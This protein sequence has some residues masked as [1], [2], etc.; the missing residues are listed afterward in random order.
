[1]PQS[2]HAVFVTFAFRLILFGVVLLLQWLVYRRF[3]RWATTYHPSSRWLLITGSS[4]FLL[5]NAAFLAILVYRPHA[6]RFP[7]WFQVAGVYPFMIWYTSTF[8]LGLVFLLV[9]LVKLPFRGALVLGT[10]LGSLREKW[11]RLTTSQ[12]FK[13]FDAQRRQ[14]LRRG[15]EGTAAVAFGSSAYGV[16]VG[17]FA[18]ETDS[19]EL[20]LDRLHPAFDGLTVT[21][22]SDIHSSVFMTK[23]EMDEYVRVVNELKSDLIVVGGDFVNGLTEEV[24]PFAESFSNLKASLGIFG[25]TGNHDY[26]ASDPER[27]IREVEAC[28]IKLLHDEKYILR[29]GDAS[30]TFLGVD[31]IGSARRASERIAVARKGGTEGAT[32]LLCHRPYFLPQAAEQ[33]V[34]L[35]LSGHTHGGQIV[36]ASV[37][38]LALTPAALASPYVAGEY[39]HGNSLMY[40]SRGIGTVGVPVRLNCPPEVTRFTLRSGRRNV[41]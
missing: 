8:F 18:Y 39:R 3:R 4:L 27:V 11:L 16:L 6:L 15:M 12:K 19:K 41:T 40:V 23:S 29:R 33:G 34:D 35:M 36:L 9:A 13:A 5:F 14:F 24:Y 17:R 2:I 38:H 37:G 10:R 32:I 30:L 20:V 31:D 1:M 22:L 7:V 26:Y 28:G 25:V 21:F